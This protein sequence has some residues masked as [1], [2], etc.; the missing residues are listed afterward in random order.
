MK[1]IFFLT[2]ILFCQMAYAN[3]YR[4][5]N[6]KNII[7]VYDQMLKNLSELNERIFNLDNQ[8]KREE[9][10]NFLLNKSGD[11]FWIAY[12]CRGVYNVY[13]MI[14]RDLQKAGKGDFIL[15]KTKDIEVRRIIYD[16]VL[17]KY[18]SLLGEAQF[19]KSSE[20]AHAEAVIYFFS[21]NERGDLIRNTSK[22]TDYT[23]QC[24]RFASAFDVENQ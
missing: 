12:T 16:E 15:F 3:D 4:L 22:I 23:R 11:G 8:T 13:T 9:V 21:E 14:N 18:V 19:N 2:F 6:E 17:K 1:K 5:K 20:L 10:T 24:N 7:R